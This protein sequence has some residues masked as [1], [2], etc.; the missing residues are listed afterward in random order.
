MTMAASVGLIGEAIAADLMSKAH[1]V[2][3]PVPQALLSLCVNL[4]LVC[5]L[6]AAG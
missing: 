3:L 6:R 2:S 5:L 1:L 4:V